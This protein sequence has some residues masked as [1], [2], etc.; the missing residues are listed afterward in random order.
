MKARFEALY[1]T[2]GKLKPIGVEVERNYLDHLKPGDRVIVTYEDW[3]AGRSLPSS[4]LAHGLLQRIAKQDREPLL[5][6]KND[7]KFLAGFYLPIETAFTH[8]PEWRGY[9]WRV[10][11]DSVWQQDVFV[12]SEA[13]FT[14]TE[15]TYFISFLHQVCNTK[16]VD[17]SDMAELFDPPEEEIW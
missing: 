3:E 16:G 10:Y 6:V 12:K 15:E 5:K 4:R 17:L 8:P 14:Q 11:S 1:T 2:E 7:L 9:P 13:D